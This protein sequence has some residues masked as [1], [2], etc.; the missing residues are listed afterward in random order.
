MPRF[1]DFFT[2]FDE[3]NYIELYQRTLFYRGSLSHCILYEK[4]WNCALW[5]PNRH[6]Y[7]MDSFFCPDEMFLY[8]L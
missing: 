6:I 5:T 3:K 7:I 2:D 1:T 4:Q 8:L